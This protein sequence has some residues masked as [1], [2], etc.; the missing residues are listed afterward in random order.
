MAFKRK[1]GFRNRVLRVIRSNAET[2]RVVQTRQFCFQTPSMSPYNA[3]GSVRI[4]ATIPPSP[5]NLYPIVAVQNGAHLGSRN[6]GSASFYCWPFKHNR[7]QRFPVSMEECIMKGINS[8]YNTVP[9]TYAPGADGP[10]AFP[11]ALTQTFRASQA[12]SRIG[13]EVWIKG[14]NFRF[15]L[16]LHASVPWMR[17]NLMLIKHRKGDYPSEFK[18]YKN[19]TS[20][21]TLDMMDTQKY[22]IL[23]KWPIYLSSTRPVPATDEVEITAGPEGGVAGT[24]MDQEVEVTAPQV[25]YDLEGKTAAEW[26]AHIAA[27]YPGYRMW[28]YDDYQHTNSASDPYWLE[29]GIGGQHDTLV[30]RYSEQDM[31]ANPAPVQEYAIVGTAGSDPD[32]RFSYIMSGINSGGYPTT[33]YTWLA[34]PDTNA[35]GVTASQC[36]IMRKTPDVDAGEEVKK[37][38]GTMQVAMDKTFDIWIPG[39]MLGNKGYIKYQETSNDLAYID[40]TNTRDGLMEYSLCFDGHYIN[41]KTLTWDST[42]T[43]LSD[44]T[45]AVMSDFLMTTYF[46][47]V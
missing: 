46:Q 34:D 40:S 30:A 33:K 43:S 14:I 29:L 41:H 45:M 24:E 15:N 16:S 8:G 10:I 6:M 25:L 7:F 35:P 26:E 5:D 23:K 11:T 39:Y 42:L 21:K 27:V 31:L 28:S 1:R 37:G 18:I 19:Y 44:P 38:E 22:K 47:D 9:G 4:P 36:L 2:K 17:T 3:D 20:V 12:M 32:A 13:T